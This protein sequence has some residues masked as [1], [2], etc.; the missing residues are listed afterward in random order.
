M[1][2]SLGLY[3]IVW[4]TESWSLIKKRIYFYTFCLQ[5]IKFQCCIEI[6][7]RGRS[8]HFSLC[9][10][11]SAGDEEKCPPAVV[12]RS[13]KVGPNLRVAQ[14]Q[15]KLTPLWHSQPPLH[16]QGLALLPREPHVP[17]FLSPRPQA[18]PFLSGWPIG[19][20]LSVC[21]SVSVLW[22][23]WCLLHRAFMESLMLLFHFPPMVWLFCYSRISKNVQIE[24]ETENKGEGYCDCS[25]A[26]M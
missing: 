5:W 4:E 2:H 7:S 20:F 16:A 14:Q 11:S 22:V 13:R 23:W 6:F 3:D 8:S 15:L 24:V 19:P 25:Y 21:A 18:F 26:M 10:L 17:F 12:S 1:A 9:G